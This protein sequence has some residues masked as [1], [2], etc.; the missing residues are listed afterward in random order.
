MEREGN[1][2]QAMY[3]LQAQETRQKWKKNLKHVGVCLF[4]YPASVHTH[5]GITRMVIFPTCVVGPGE[6]HSQAAPLKLQW[7]R[8]P[9]SSE[10]IRLNLFSH[11]LFVHFA[12]GRER[13]REMGE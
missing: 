12:G 6:H 8:S 10:Q 2:K 11:F 9:L 1:K 4:T 7:P 13:E 5:V 3:V